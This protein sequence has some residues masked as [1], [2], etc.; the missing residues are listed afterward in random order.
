MWALKKWCVT[1]V[2]HCTTGK[3]EDI[4]IWLRAFL[5]IEYFSLRIIPR[6]LVADRTM[7]SICECHCP[8]LLK[9]TP[10]CL[11]LSTKLIGI[12]S[13]ISCGKILIF[14]RVIKTALVFSGLNVTSHCLAEFDNN[15]I[16]WLIILAMSSMCAA[17]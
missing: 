9:V 10:R 6:I 11:W 15:C 3:R 7:F 16:S 12:L 4:Y 14:L 5:L 1:K 2:A 17:E 8:V 13:K